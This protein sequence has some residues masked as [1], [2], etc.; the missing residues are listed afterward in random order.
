MHIKKTLI[1][2]DM[3]NLE[4]IMKRLD[5]SVVKNTSAKAAIDFSI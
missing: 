5:K 1:G 3:D 4:E 2:M